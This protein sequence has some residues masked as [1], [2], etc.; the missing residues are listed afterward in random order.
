MDVLELFVREFAF[1]SDDSESEQQQNS[2]TGN[3]FFFS[4]TLSLPSQ[5]TNR[6]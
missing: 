5:E 1:A 3:S 4:L 2:V 6:S